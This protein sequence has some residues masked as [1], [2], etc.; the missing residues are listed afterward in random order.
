MSENQ[1]AE[2]QVII[3][4][5]QELRDDLDVILEC[6]ANGTPRDLVELS[7]AYGEAQIPRREGNMIDMLLARAQ[8]D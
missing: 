7:S 6:Q 8:R 4:M 3:Q 5:I 1:T 2:E